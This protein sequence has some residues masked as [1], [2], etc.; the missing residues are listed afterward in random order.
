VSEV[1]LG[2]SQVV[3][4]D[5]FLQPDRNLPTV[6]LVGVRYGCFGLFEYVEVSF[7]WGGFYPVTDIN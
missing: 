1:V 4:A 5:R 7:D 3:K 2:Q 6:G